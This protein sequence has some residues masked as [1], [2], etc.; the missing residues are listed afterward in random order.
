MKFKSPTVERAMTRLSQSVAGGFLIPFLLVLLIDFTT[1]GDA[2]PLPLGTHPLGFILTWPYP[3]WKHFLLPISAYLATIVSHIVIYS[4]LT[5]WFI[6][7]RA[8][9]KRLKQLP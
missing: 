9:L 7:R 4:L 8:D 2:H 3:L 5:Y 6:R 1:K